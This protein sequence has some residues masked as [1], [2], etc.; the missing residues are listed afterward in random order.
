MIDRLA[1]NGIDLTRRPI[2]VAPIA[3]YHMGGVRVD[4]RMETRIEGLFAA[5]EAVG[6]ANGANRLSGNAIPEAFV[7]GERAGR[8][9]AKRGGE[10]VVWRTGDD[11]RAQ[12]L[13]DGA[14]GT[15]GDKAAGL[16]ALLRELQVLMWDDVGLLRTEQGLSRALDRIREMRSRD[17]P[18]LAPERKTHFDHALLDWLDL[19]ASLLAAESV[20]LA[21]RNRKESRGAHQ[22]E[23]FVETDPACARNQVVRLSSEGELECGWAGVV[24]APHARAPLEAAE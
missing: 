9:A 19:R 24:T 8:F 14:H 23:D 4:D 15:G 2:E 5:G 10:A 20:A 7:F 13:I 12:A 6:G 22:R 18:T 17:M 1:K 3:H 16:G 21:A 11:A